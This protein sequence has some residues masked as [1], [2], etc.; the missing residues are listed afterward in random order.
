[1]RIRWI[2]IQ[3]TLLFENDHGNLDLKVWLMTP[4]T[5]SIIM[6][7]I[8]INNFHIL[9]NGILLH[10][11]YNGHNHNTNLMDELNQ[12]KLLIGKVRL[13]SLYNFLCSNNLNN[14]NLISLLHNNNYNFH[15][16]HHQ[17]FLSLHNLIRTPTIKHFSLP[18]QLI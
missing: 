12:N 6:F 16:T 18:M 8:L 3:P 13:I 10:L 2:G 14:F 7:K 17:D 4:L 15:P 1:M 9:V 5:F 11:G